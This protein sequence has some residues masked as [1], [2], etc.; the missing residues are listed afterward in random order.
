MKGWSKAYSTEQMANA[1]PEKLQAD[2]LKNKKMFDLLQKQKFLTDKMNAGWNK[3]F[4]MFDSLQKVTDI[5]RADLDHQ[6]K[7]LFEELESGDIDGDRR[8]AI[9]NQIYEENMNFC[10]AYNPRYCRIIYEYKQHLSEVLFKYDYDT[11]ENVQHEILNFQLGVEVP[12]YKPGLYALEAVDGYASL[13]GTVFK[14]SV[15]RNW[16]MRISTSD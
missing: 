13:L 2:A 8:E 9:E 7:P 6:L 1:D 16:G 3:Y 15:A 14:F 12:N 4:Q 5:A 11:L 10:Q